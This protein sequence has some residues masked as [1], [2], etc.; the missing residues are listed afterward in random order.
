MRRI[1][2]RFT[3]ARCGRSLCELCLLGRRGI[4]TSVCVC[5]STFDQY[6]N[7]WL[8]YVRNIMYL[9]A[10]MHACIDACAHAY[11]ATNK[12]NE[13]ERKLQQANGMGWEEG[14]FH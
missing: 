8:R 5:L 6:V 13:F 10:Y 3:F 1:L 14:W 2:L 11:P 7:A 9:H 12:C 4:E